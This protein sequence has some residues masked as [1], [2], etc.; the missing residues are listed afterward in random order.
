MKTSDVKNMDG[1]QL[2]GRIADMVI[3]SM[4]LSY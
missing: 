4:V 1:K 3:E 2:P